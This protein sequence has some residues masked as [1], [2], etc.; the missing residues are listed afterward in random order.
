M[1]TDVLK[2]TADQKVAI[3]FPIADIKSP[4]DAKKRKK[5]NAGD[6]LHKMRPESQCERMHL[7]SLFWIASIIIL[8]FIQQQITQFTI[9]CLPV[10]LLQ[11]RTET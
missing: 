11:R 10:K 2:C 4:N 6:N 5:K 9:M 3:L 8:C 7:T 1:I